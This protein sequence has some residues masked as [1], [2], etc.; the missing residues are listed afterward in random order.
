LALTHEA[1]GEQI[2]LA[3]NI[4]GLYLYRC[5]KDNDLM[6]EIPL[7]EKTFWVNLYS[8][9]E[10]PEYIGLLRHKSFEDAK[11]FVGIL[12]DCKFCYSEYK[13][14]LKITYTEEDLIK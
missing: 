1:D 8:T 14:T 5:D 11:S 2:L 10:I 12:L 4:D 9:Q 6:L 3:C 7:E 13:G